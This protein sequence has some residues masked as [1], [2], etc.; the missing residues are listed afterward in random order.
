MWFE[1]PV[2]VGWDPLKLYWSTDDLHDLKFNEEK[3]VLTFRAGRL[4]PLALAAF[5]Y[6]NL[7]YQTWEL[8]PNASEH[9]TITLSITAAVVLVEFTFKLMRRGG[10][11]VFP[12]H[13]AHCYMAA[14]SPKQRPPERHLYKCMALA[15]S[16]HCFAWSRWNLLAGRTKMVFQMRECHQDESGK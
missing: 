9:E 7:P 13:D 4:G 6:S 3:Q 14:V 10:V 16:T 15:A 11:D 5:R 8:R 2:V 1:P 12:P